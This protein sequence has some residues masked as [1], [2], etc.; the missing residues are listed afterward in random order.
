MTRLEKLKE[1][2]QDL[3]KMMEKA[4][5]RVYAS[6]AKQYRETLY[7]IE[8]IEGRNDNDDELGEIIQNRE[9]DGKPAANCQNRSELN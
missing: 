9:A 8:M 3:K 4:N 5:S 2:E 1:L 6:L 7:E